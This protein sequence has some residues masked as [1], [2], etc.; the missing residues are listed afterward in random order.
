MAFVDGAPAVEAPEGFERI[1][2]GAAA[3]PS[4]AGSAAGGSWFVFSPATLALAAGVLVLIGAAR[5]WPGG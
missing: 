5:S 3:S 4:S 2:V 1:G